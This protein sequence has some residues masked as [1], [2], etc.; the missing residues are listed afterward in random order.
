MFNQI[1]FS[2]RKNLF[3]IA[4]KFNINWNKR[5]V[6]NK[7]LFSRTNEENLRK[8]PIDIETGNDQKKEKALIRRYDAYRI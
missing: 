1:R 2:Y 8:R 4:V 6:Y 5:T 7:L 3:K